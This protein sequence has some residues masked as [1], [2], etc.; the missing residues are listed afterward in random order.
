MPGAADRGDVFAFGGL[1]QTPVEVQLALALGG[2][3]TGCDLECRATE[4]LHEMV[5]FRANVAMVEI[6]QHDL[7]LHDAF[8]PGVAGGDHRAGRHEQGHAGVARPCRLK[9]EFRG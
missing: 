9:R 6:D 3:T 1:G 4:V 5:A 7:R 2:D 8:R